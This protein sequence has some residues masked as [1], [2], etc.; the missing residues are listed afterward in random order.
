M[1]EAM[2]AID[3]LTIT[4]PGGK[5]QLP[6]QRQ[7]DVRA[8][9]NASIRIHPGETL[10]LV[11]ESGSGKTTIGRAILRFIK[12]SGGSIR[13]GDFDVTSFGRSVPAEYRR[14][15]QVVFQDPFG[16]FNSASISIVGLSSARRCQLVLKC[17]LPFSER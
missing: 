4:F 12:P 15:V 10:G 13:L 8:V 16:S 7:P 5:G 11:G 17:S 9:Q 14:A 3:D 2:L 6:W 1:T